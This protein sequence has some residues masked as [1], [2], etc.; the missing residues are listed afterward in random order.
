MS[1]GEAWLI[2][3]IGGALAGIIT[4][5]VLAIFSKRV[6][7]RLW[8]PI[9]RALRWPLTLRVT[10][11][12][13]MRA[14]AEELERAQKQNERSNRFYADL[15][16]AL[17]IVVLSGDKQLLERIA[18][19]RGASSSADQRAAAAV[20]H[21]AEQI[22]ATQALAVDE[23]DRVSKAHQR[24]LQSAIASARAEGR[25]QAIGI[26]KEQRERSPLLRP[27]WRVVY[28][29][30]DRFLLNNTQSGVEIS[31]VSIAA[32]LGDFEFI[33]DTQWP[34]PYSG[35]QQFRGR[36][37]RNGRSFGVKF[38]IRYRD[39]D[40]EWRAGEAWIDKEPRQAVVL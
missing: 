25:Q 1:S 21:A 13:R 14:R 18:Q 34:G 17:G 4:A 38:A 9:G 6:R 23:A 20:A 40:G 22:A 15:C 8:M 3:I 10:T 2:A 35:V 29:E 36:R 31:D 28:L 27:T 37:M 24:E 11:T 16:E 26:L 33:G 32:P 39:A 7:V 19:L 30:D 5:A 12:R